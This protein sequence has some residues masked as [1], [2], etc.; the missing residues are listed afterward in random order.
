ME[1]IRVKFSIIQPND[2]RAKKV[3]ITFTVLV[4]LCVIATAWTG[5]ID[6][7]AHAVLNE[8]M[9]RTI[10]TFLTLQALDAA[11]SLAQSAQSLP[12]IGVAISVFGRKLEPLNAILSQLS[13]LMF[14]STLILGTIKL[15]LAISAHWIVSLIVTAIV[16]IIIAYLAL[17]I[18]IPRLIYATS[19]M[20]I[21]IRFAI[22]VTMVSSEM[23]FQNFLFD[24][25]ST[26]QGKFN[27]I[28]TDAD[29]IGDQNTLKSEN[30][31]SMIEKASQVGAGIYQ[32]IL[33]LQN[34]IESAIKYTIS[35]SIIFLLQTIVIPFVILAT[36]I[37]TSQKLFRLTF[38][39][40]PTEKPMKITN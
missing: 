14:I 29:S 21:L 24:E 27:S 7:A 15:L 32:W 39:T 20:V 19:I 4:S 2:E 35:L 30:K 16:V 5:P 40:D 34:S 37:K 6:A 11:I 33:K 26:T 12:Y 23:V 9:A 1:E 17:E 22:P 18:T 8:T 28:A 36:L 38:K 25:Y 10:A 13:T 31:L 3:K